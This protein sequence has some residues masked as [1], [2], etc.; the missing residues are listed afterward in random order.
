M[1]RGALSG[2][3][4]SYEASS[5][6]VA[7]PLPVWAHTHTWKKSQSLH[8]P[9]VPLMAEAEGDLQERAASEEPETEAEAGTAEEIDPDTLPF[10]SVAYWTH[11]Y[12]ED[13]EMDFYEWYSADEWLPQ[14]T[15]KVGAR[16]F[17]SLRPCSSLSFCER[18]GVAH[19]RRSGA[20]RARA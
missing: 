4:L 16:I 8:S 10:N 12:Q 11:F 15:E 14:A 9:P 18:F 17:L 3:L 13:E 1:T 2:A 5:V 7:L 19:A 20:A 6:L